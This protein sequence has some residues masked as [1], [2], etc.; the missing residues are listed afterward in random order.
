MQVTDAIAAKTM[1]RLNPDPPRGPP[2]HTAWYL[3][4]HPA[5]RHRDPLHKGPYPHPRVN[6]THVRQGQNL[7]HRPLGINRIEI[8]G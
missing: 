5:P 3:K 6:L 1:P 8:R 2:Y 4:A 7:L